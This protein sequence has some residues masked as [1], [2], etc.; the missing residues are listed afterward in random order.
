[1]GAGGGQLSQEAGGGARI[2]LQPLAV[3]LVANLQKSPSP[4]Y[5]WG[6]IRGWRLHWL[7]DSPASLR[8][9]LSFWGGQVT[10]EMAMRQGPE[11]TGALSEKG[12]AGAN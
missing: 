1:M 3:F 4:P 5:S 7:Y 6:T 2:W 12:T 10:G 11:S 8:A 9:E